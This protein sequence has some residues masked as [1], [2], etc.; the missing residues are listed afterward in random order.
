MRMERIGSGRA[1]VE[2]SAL[3]NGDWEHAFHCEKKGG[4]DGYPWR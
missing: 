3:G 4:K 2:E 1:H